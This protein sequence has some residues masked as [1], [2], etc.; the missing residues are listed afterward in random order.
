MQ[1]SRPQSPVVGSVSLSPVSSNFSTAGSPVHTRL[2]E[3]QPSPKS[4]TN[5]DET[6]RHLQ[7][8]ISSYESNSQGN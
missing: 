3:K 2:N 7:A 1:N 6:I 4:S 8:K 5:P